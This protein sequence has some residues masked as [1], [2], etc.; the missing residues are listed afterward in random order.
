[1]SARTIQSEVFSNEPSIANHAGEQLRCPEPNIAKVRVGSTAAGPST[2][3]ALRQLGRTDEINEHYGQLAPFGAPRPCVTLLRQPCRRAS[4]V[5]GGR[6][7]QQ[8]VRCVSQ[9]SHRGKQPAP[10]T[11]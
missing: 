7:E 1:M 9:G 5:T 4:T 2:S 6:V 10:V 8:P 11:N 3:E